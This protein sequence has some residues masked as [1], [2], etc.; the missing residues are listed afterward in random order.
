M[1][2]SPLIICA[3]ACVLLFAGAASAQS[4]N[5]PLGGSQFNPP[6]PPP[7]NVPKVTVPVVPKFDQP[8]QPLSQ[9]APQPSFSEKVSRCADEGA[10]VGLTQ[11]ERSAYTRSCVNR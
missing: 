6:P 5:I 2:R 4:T 9:S 11:G 10:V 8:S 3:T 1:T 7:P